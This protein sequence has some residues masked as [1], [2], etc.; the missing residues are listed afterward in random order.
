[1]GKKICMLDRN[2]M[3]WRG[4]LA[5]LNPLSQI[6]II[7]RAPILLLLPPSPNIK[8]LFNVNFHHKMLN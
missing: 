3:N 4:A 8:I 1:M 7:T 6:S 5:P 2:I